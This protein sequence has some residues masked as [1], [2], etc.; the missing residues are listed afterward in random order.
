MVMALR[1]A[2]RAEVPTKL[3]GVVLAGGRETAKPIKDAFQMRRNEPVVRAQRVE[4]IVEIIRGVVGGPGSRGPHCLGERGQTMCIIC[5]S[6][7]RHSYSPGTL[8][9]RSRQ[10]RT[11]PGRAPAPPSPGARR[12]P[13]RRCKTSSWPG[14]GKGCQFTHFINTIESE[15]YNFSMKYFT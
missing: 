14:T 9:D 11:P 4:G 1:W 10:A 5:I 7:Q 3:D 6:D 12:L 8:W 15:L 13:S 2:G